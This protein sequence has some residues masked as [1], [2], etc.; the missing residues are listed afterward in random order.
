[1]SNTHITP[2]IIAKCILS[3][4]SALDFPAGWA[5]HEVTFTTAD[6]VATIDDMSKRV[7]DPVAEKLASKIGDSPHKELEMP[8]AA[9]NCWLETWKD[10]S[11]AVRVLPIYD[12][13]DDLMKMCIDLSRPAD[14]LAREEAWR[15]REHGAELNARD[16]FVRGD[17]WT[18][19]EIDKMSA[20]NAEPLQINMIKRPEIS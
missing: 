6:L 20:R 8:Q 14:W 19:D 2:S 5:S 12:G 17:R 16:I 10:G 3:H 4:L 9:Y 15:L 13:T 1:M 11:I 18:Q 7:L